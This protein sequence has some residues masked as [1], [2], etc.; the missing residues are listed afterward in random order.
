[1]AEAKSYQIET[2]E[3]KSLLD[4][5]ENVA[6]L[7]VREGWEYKICS[8][9][10]SRLFPLAELPERAV[11]LRASGLQKERLLVVVCHH[12]M[13]SFH[14]TLWLRQNGFENAVN[15]SGGIDAWARDVDPD[16]QRY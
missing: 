5:G 13:R 14:A 12:G 8:F 16:M 10:G 9:S 1:M 15:L 11:E 2:G 4:A 3:L 7:D 6:I